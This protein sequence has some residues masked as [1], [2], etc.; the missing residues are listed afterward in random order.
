MVKTPVNIF[1]MYGLV[2]L[3]IAGGVVTVSHVTSTVVPV[4]PKYGQ[5]SIDLVLSP[6]VGQQSGSSASY[7]PISD[8]ARQE[9]DTLRVT[10]DSIMIYHS[11]TL[12]P[13]T[14]W[15]TL[16]EETRTVT[17][18]TGVKVHLGSITLPEGNITLVRVK[19]ISATIQRGSNG[20]LEDIGIQ[21]SQFDIQTHARVNA[22]TTTNVLVD[23]HVGCPATVNDNSSG[24]SECSLTPSV[25]SED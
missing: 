3:A 8:Y 6:S 22:Q 11:G 18:R 17:L 7:A 25:E 12:S 13:T 2:G 21:S 9:D 14:N 1:V 23:F 4:F 10:T 5:L 16:Q 20:M 24:H 15:T 19:I